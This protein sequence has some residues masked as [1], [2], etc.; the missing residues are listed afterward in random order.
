MGSRMVDALDLRLEIITTLFPQRQPYTFINREPEVAHI[1]PEVTGEEILAACTR[2]GDRPDM[3]ANV[4]Y[5]CFVES[6]FPRRWKEQKL[7]LNPKPG[8]PPG[9]PSSYHLIC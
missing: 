6:V 5:K 7:V 2:I 9:E 3:F 8:K 1:I 4:F